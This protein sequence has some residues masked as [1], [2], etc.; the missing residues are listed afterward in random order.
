M[1]KFNQ[2]LQAELEKSAATYD[3]T[4]ISSEVIKMLESV[5]LKLN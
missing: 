2:Q 4:K 5:S 1:S 3:D